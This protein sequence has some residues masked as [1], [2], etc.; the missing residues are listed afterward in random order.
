M[1]NLIEKV[2]WYYSL[3]IYYNFE[4]NNLIKVFIV[5]I[6]KQKLDF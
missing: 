1:K 3:I 5:S 2:F 6:K 4:D